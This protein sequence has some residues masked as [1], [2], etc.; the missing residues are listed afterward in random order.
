M[1]QDL[2]GSA[3]ANVLEHFFDSIA[4][5]NRGDADIEVLELDGT[6]LRYEV[7]IRHRQVAKIR[8]PFNG[9]KEVIVYSLT[10]Y[11]RGKIDIQ[12]PAPSD[13][14]VCVDT[15][16]GQICVTLTEVIAIIAGLV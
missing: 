13:Q 2:R 12:N 4:Q 5:G 3:A 7:K 8:I 6:V 14:T 1:A 10:T 9:T 15:P 16:V 11:A